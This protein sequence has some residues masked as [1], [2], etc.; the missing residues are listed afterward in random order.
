MGGERE[1]HRFL[2]LKEVG[3][4]ASRRSNRNLCGND[5]EYSNERYRQ[6]VGF[7]GGVE[8]RLP[9]ST[10]RWNCIPSLVFC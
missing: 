4:I 9:P 6:L 3:P 2:L 8:F 7:D 5:R 1:I 10:L